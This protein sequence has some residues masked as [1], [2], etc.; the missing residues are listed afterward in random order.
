MNENP[1]SRLKATLLTLTLLAMLFTTPAV[2]L[3]QQGDLPDNTIFD[4]A[5]VLTDAQE[6]DV[7]ESFEGSGTEIY[8]FLESDTG[9]VRGDAQ[10]Q[11]EYAQNLVNQEN[12]PGGTGVV[13]LAPEE[14]WFQT[15]LPN[16]VR[17]D[18]SAEFGQE[19]WAEGLIAGAEG[20]SGGAA[21][22]G[23]SGA[24]SGAGAD[25]GFPGG[26]LLLL[27]L[28]AIAGLF[29]LARN[30]RTR[31]RKLV[32]NRRKAEEGFT[33]LTDRINA[34]SEKERLVSGYL[35]AQ[36]PLL[37]Q[38]T[39]GEIESRIREAN[40]LGFGK[41]LNEAGGQL[42]S[43]PT[44]ALA[45]VEN[46]RK[47]LDEAD[48]NLDEA[49]KEIDH[50][51]A[52]DEALDGHLR[53]AADEMALAE[54]AE[55]RALEAGADIDPGNPLRPEYDRLAREAAARAAN[56]DEYDPRE[57]VAAT[58]ALAEKARARRAA[59]EDE[60]D[61][62]AA[63]PGL[64]SSTLAALGRERGV[65]EQYGRTHA[66]T[67]SEWG[68]AALENVPAPGELGAG[69]REAEGLVAESDR[70]AGARRFAE[71]RARLEE[72]RSRADAV[73]N[74]P[75]ALKTAVVE[76]DRKKREGEEKL[77]ELEG[78]LAEAR[79]YEHRMGPSGRRRLREYE[80]RV[81]DARGTFFG[82]DFLTAFLLFEAL[83]NDFTYVDGD[84]FG[85]FGGDIDGGDFGGGDFGGGDFGGGGFGGGDF[86]GGG[87]GGGDFGGG[88][89]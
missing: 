85:G 27:P 7:Q 48:R 16:S 4:E 65:L 2:A 38:A 19:A 12:V 74:A 35:E 58:T 14:R 25:A 28:V 46:G 63:L 73:V 81:G 20:I 76:A 80:R 11:V 24:G 1:A 89:F 49:E 70:L 69:L 3:A 23:G 72:A 5:D 53:E 88:D 34:F 56:R 6:R 61:S 57:A 68:P 41:E 75:A 13:V 82:G 40:S 67:E 36:R 86:G 31:R 64:R 8:A 52:A 60:V 33:D 77:Q 9:V 55:H 43:D 10:A 29:L 54:A 26:G 51:R 47:L 78:R 42:E 84:P 15:N 45:G 17:D 37:D 21:S 44:A 22:Q 83:D 79:Q 50:Y 39:E 66:A 30:R 62:K 71:A 59:M 87:F 18:M 32:E